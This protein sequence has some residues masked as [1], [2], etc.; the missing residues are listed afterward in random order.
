MILT[1]S[2][3]CGGDSS[4]ETR[5]TAK[6]SSLRGGRQ[7]DAAIWGMRLLRVARNDDIVRLLRVAR[8]DDI[9]R[10]L[11]VARNDDTFILLVVHMLQGALLKGGRQPDAAIW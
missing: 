3:T 2:T 5:I 10:L 1:V 6:Q 8:N 9:V 11:R 4:N 7:P